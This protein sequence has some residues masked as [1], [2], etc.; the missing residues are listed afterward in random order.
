MAY[1]AIVKEGEPVLRKISREV[2]EFNDKLH[3]LLDDMF[4][5][6]YK[7]EGVGLA[8]PQVG[9]LRRVIVV[10]CGQRQIE[11]VN[12]V[13]LHSSGEVGMVEGCLSVPGKSGYV[14]RA[15]KIK[16]GFQTRYGEKKTKT[17]FD[18]EA[19]A[20]QHEIDH[21]NGILY[22]DKVVEEETDK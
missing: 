22:I 21:L 17:F 18:F 14:K 15:Q 3:T 7:A 16:V 1:R 19:R 8:G 6:M 20:L 2:T 12:P 13:I 4:D 11:M 10:D 9:I 5:T